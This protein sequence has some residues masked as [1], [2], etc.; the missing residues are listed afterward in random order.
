MG[1][2]NVRG[3][4]RHGAGDHADAANGAFGGVPYGATKRLRGV[5][6]W[7][8]RRHVDPAAGASVELLWGHETCERCAEMG[9]ADA[10]GRRHW[11]LRWN[12]DGAAERVSAVPKSEAFG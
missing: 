6:K 10:C 3:V 4:R 1:P 8:R 9:G 2:R 5:P 7:A 12:S 11:D